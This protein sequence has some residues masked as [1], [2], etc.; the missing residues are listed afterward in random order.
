[1]NSNPNTGAAGVAGIETQFKELLRPTK[2]AWPT[3][4]LF[5]VSLGGL[6]LASYLAVTGQIPLWVGLIINSILSFFLLS[7][8]H[9]AT[10]NAISR[11]YPVIAQRPLCPPCRWKH[12]PATS[13]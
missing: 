13:S 7:V 4:I 8:A 11:T 6:A 3:V 9:D 1:M 2:L 10:H 12:I 5:F